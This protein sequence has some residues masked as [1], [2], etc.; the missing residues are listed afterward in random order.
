V[1]ENSVTSCIEDDPRTFHYQE[2]IPENTYKE[3]NDFHHKEKAFALNYVSDAVVEYN[4][5]MDIIWANKAACNLADLKLKE[6]IGKNRCYDIFDGCSYGCGQC[7]V[8]RSFQN[9]QQYSIELKT[10]DNRIFSVT[11]IPFLDSNGHVNSV[12]KLIRDRTC[13]RIVENL[14]SCDYSGIMAFSLRLETLTHRDHEVMSL[15]VQGKS[16]NRISAELSISPKTVEIH[17]SRVMKKLQAASL[18]ELVRL[19]TQLEFFR[20]CKLK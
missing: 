14:L 4:R 9:A 12:I 2:S 19:S 7:P 18:A 10:K 11:A 6:L 16:N 5:N 20:R 15:A 3:S 13:Q 17:R 1:F 8:K